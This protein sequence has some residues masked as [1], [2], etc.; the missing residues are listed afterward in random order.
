MSG[1]GDTPPCPDANGIGTGCGQ[2]VLAV[3][4]FE[5]G[6]NDPTIGALAEA[7]VAV[8][9]EPLDWY[10][11]LS[12]GKLDGWEL[13]GLLPVIPTNAGKTIRKFI[14]AGIADDA[15]RVVGYWRSYSSNK[16]WADYQDFITGVSRMDY[17]YNGVGFDGIIASGSNGTINSMVLLDAKFWSAGFVDNMMKG[18][19]RNGK[20]YDKIRNAK[21]GDAWRQVNAADGIQ[22]QW[23]FNS[24]AAADMW[25]EYLRK[26]GIS[27]AKIDVIW[28]P[29]Q[30]GVS[31]ID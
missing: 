8:L 11:A 24:K 12:D 14:P 25:R 20:N 21:I 23:H 2:T 28:T 19:I 27:Q 30:K 3:S 16:R 17:K 4:S 29:W 1:G 26:E 6:V 9:Y 7:A 15:G 13:L 5:P 18:G 31:P 22:I 10:F